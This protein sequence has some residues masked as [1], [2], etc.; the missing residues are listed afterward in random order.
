MQNKENHRQ[1]VTFIKLVYSS[2]WYF[3]LNRLPLIFLEFLSVNQWCP[4][5]QHGTNS[6][7]LPRPKNSYTTGCVHV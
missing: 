2:V 4:S 1:Q 5:L 3:R 7:C 6:S